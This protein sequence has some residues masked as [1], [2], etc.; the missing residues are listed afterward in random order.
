VRSEA[1][2]A[3]IS[4]VVLDNRVRAGVLIVL[5]DG[6]YRHAAAPYTQDLRD[7]AAVLACGPDAVLSHRSAAARH[8]FPDVRRTRPEVTSPHT[9]LPRVKDV[10]R[11]RSRRL[12]PSQIITVNGIRMTT[13]GRTALDFCAVTPLEVATEVISAAVVTKLLEPDDILVAI[14]RSGGRGCPGTA[15]LRVIALG[16]DDIEDLESVLELVV[17][18]VL[19]A[20]RVPRA[21]RQH[22]LTC[23]DGRRVR[24]DFAWPDDR[25]SLDADGKRWH[26]TPARKKRTRERHDS[27][28]ATGWVHIVVGWME[29]TE[30]PDEICRTVEDAVDAR[31]SEKAA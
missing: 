17:A 12:P 7:L 24:L 27:I 25:V 21:V 3:G 16:L 31:R 19:D 10:T 13:K 26:A 23:A 2:A 4:E 14:E 11:H 8:R 18:R 15:H 30:T 29:A 6:I 5:H 28:V 9:D 22:D 1:L 20:A